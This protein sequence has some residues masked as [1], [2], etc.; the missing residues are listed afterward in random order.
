MLFAF[1]D[2]HTNFPNALIQKPSMQINK[3][4]SIK[5]YVEDSK[6][7]WK[8]LNIFTCIQQGHIKLIANDSKYINNVTKDFYLK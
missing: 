1:R 3:K 5:I 7:L 6:E 8:I 2:L 4:N